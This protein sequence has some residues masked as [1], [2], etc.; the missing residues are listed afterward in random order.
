MCYSLETIKQGHYSDVKNLWFSP[1]LT[2]LCY[3]HI[4][5]SHTGPTALKWYRTYASNNSFSDQKAHI[6][7]LVFCSRLT[8][9]QVSEFSRASMDVGPCEGALYQLSE[10]AALFS[11]TGHSRSWVSASAPQG[12]GAATGHNCWLS[13]VLLLSECC[14][15]LRPQ[16][17]TIISALPSHFGSHLL[18]GDASA[19][20]FCPE[21]YGALCKI[22]KISSLHLV[23][24]S[25]IRD[26]KGAV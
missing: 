18:H 9:G 23:F 24:F 10:P 17:A 22:I 7:F 8:Q 19:Y 1:A 2:A 26:Q 15:A 25:L 5:N 16:Y 12:P 20:K 21:V 4:T 3:Y 6:L 14:Q 13:L 11:L